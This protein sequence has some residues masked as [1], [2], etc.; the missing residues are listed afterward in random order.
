VKDS[1]PVLWEFSSYLEELKDIEEL[2]VDVS[3]D[4]DG[5]LG[6]LDVGLL[7]E[8]LLHSVAECPH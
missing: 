1:L 2:A 6:L 5:C 8:Q 7:E 3:A 4:C